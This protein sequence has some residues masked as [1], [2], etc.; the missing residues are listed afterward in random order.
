LPPVL[1]SYLPVSIRPIDSAEVF[2]LLFNEG[3]IPACWFFRSPCAV[4]RITLS[5]ADGEQCAGGRRGRVRPTWV[6]GHLTTIYR[7]VGCFHLIYSADEAPDFIGKRRQTIC[8]ANTCGVFVCT[9][10][11]SENHSTPNSI[12]CQLVCGTGRNRQ[13]ITPLESAGR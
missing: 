8:Y 11:S 3:F 6:A 10:Q 7:F 12:S 13:T 2:S 1:V 4:F 9:L 5:T